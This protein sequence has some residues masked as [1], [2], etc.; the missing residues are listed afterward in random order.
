MRKGKI[1]RHFYPDKRSAGVIQF[2]AA[3]AGGII[4]LIIKHFFHKEKAVL[5]S[6]LIILCICTAAIFIYI[7][8]YFSKL[9]YIAT[10]KEIIRISGVFFKI[11]Q[12]VRYSS[13]QYVSVIKT[14]LSGYTGLNFVILFVFGGRFRLM[15]LSR[16]D[17]DEILRLSGSTYG[18]ES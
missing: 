9:K 1:M 11:H 17:A 2:L 16:D 5:L 8:L 15:F 14:F 12:S 10:D 3:A 4:F 6:G 7:P 13:I 18:G